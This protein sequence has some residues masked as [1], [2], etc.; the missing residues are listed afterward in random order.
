MGFNLNNKDLPHVFANPIHK[1]I[2]NNKQVFYSD[3]NDTRTYKME[4]IP[5]K[6]NEIFSSPNHVYKS[7]VHIKTINQEFDAVIVGKTSTSLLTL[8]GDR[9]NI[10]EITFIDKI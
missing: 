6:I 1:E 9:I 8:N 3:M 7:K 10:G 4:N 5:R 2:G